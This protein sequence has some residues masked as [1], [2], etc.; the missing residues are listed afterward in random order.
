M[1]LKNRTCYNCRVK[2]HERASCPRLNAPPM[3]PRQPSPSESERE[4]ENMITTPV[5]RS[6]LGQQSQTYAQVCR[7]CTT[8]TA[9]PVMTSTPRAEPAKV[10]RLMKNMTPEQRREVIHL[11]PPDQRPTRTVTVGFVGHR[12]T[13][14]IEMP[15][16][17]SSIRGARGEHA[18]VD[19]G[20]NENLID[21]R[22]ALRWGITPQKL[23]IPIVCTNVNGT[24]NKGSKITS[25]VILEASYGNK[26]EE[27]LFLVA[28]LGKDRTIFGFP[29]LRAF[30]PQINWM[31]M[32]CVTVMRT[33]RSIP[34]CFSSISHLVL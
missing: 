8:I 23:P 19:S 22:T 27:L 31:T 10:A 26:R 9:P 21:K 30:N 5:S 28:D 29:W 1:A 13:R 11:L 18:L 17:F 20:A 6:T 16:T 7:T 12:G 33:A 32:T 25:Y 3:A 34:Y 24:T 4:V 2:G 14:S 15:F